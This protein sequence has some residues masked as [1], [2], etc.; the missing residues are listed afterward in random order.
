MAMTLMSLSGQTPRSEGDATP[1]TRTIR[2]RPASNAATRASR[3]ATRR[4]NDHHRH[5]LTAYPAA[6][7]RTSLAGSRG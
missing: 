1:H 2:G 5:H 4:R 6:G 3:L 7:S